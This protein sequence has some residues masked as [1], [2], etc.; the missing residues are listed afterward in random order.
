MSI[1]PPGSE[2]DGRYTV[3]QLLGEGGMNRVYLV[4]DKKG[5]RFALKVSRDPSELHGGGDDLQAHFFRE[6]AI[7]KLLSH[8]SLPRLYDHF[9]A[10]SQ[11]Y[12]I[13]EYVMGTSL[14]E[15]ARQNTLSE[16]EVLEL[17]ITLLGILEYLH[18][19]K[20]V[21]RDLKP[22]NIIV[23]PDGRLKL[24]DFDIARFYKHGKASDT[25]ALGTPGYAA[26]ETYGKA[27]SDSRSDLYSLGAT[28]HQLLTGLD[29]QHRPFRFQTSSLSGV[30]SD[31]ATA[32]EKALKLDP[33]ERFPSAAE[34][35]K[36]LERIRSSLSPSKDA[37]ARLL[38]AVSSF[39]LTMKQ[40]GTDA[41]NT[42]REAGALISKTPLINAVKNGDAGQVQRVLSLQVNL[43]LAT[44]VEERDEM[45]RSALHWAI[46][47][48]R[49]EIAEMLLAKGAQADSID[50]TGMTP[51]DY[52]VMY[53]RTE[54]LDTLVP[55]CLKLDLNR[56]SYRCLL[57]KAIL[58]GKSEMTR[59]LTEK[60]APLD[61]KDSE[62][63]T[64]LHCAALKGDK[65]LVDFL[66]SRG[67][68]VQVVDKN[69]MTA[70]HSAVHGGNLDIVRHFLQQGVPPDLKDSHGATALHY[71]AA[72][73]S[74]TMADFFITLGLAPDITDVQG[75]TPLERAASRGNA[76]IVRFLKEKGADINKCD[77]E[78]RSL[79]MRAVIAG[80]IPMSE[81]LID[82]GAAVNNSDDSG[83][84]P[85]HFAAEKGD[86]ALVKLLI[87]RGAEVNAREKRG[88]TPFYEA[89]S[90]DR[91]ELAAILLEKNADLCRGDN[92]GMTPLHV[93]ARKGRERMVKFLMDRGARADAIN[94]EGRT[95]LYYAGRKSVADL[96]RRAGSK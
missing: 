83:K 5:R 11:L 37:F 73:G 8:P 30:R 2:I 63:R 1:L 90:H 33:D 67:A 85:L 59:A 69:G 23:T 48:N 28:L 13:E 81:L 35:R 84:T 22:A 17:G 75:A 96:L 47:D 55:W 70:F 10:G 86:E 36:A 19:Q 60:G 93:A 31:L 57:H 20:I 52:V 61:V 12:L 16:A 6:V 66:L 88:R 44:T 79:L 50:N 53:N 14:E 76:E 25:V 82:G 27:Q 26:P 46:I 56:G 54:L 42:V 18:S 32:V 92:G 15:Y 41:V 43:P 68:R 77:G 51:F 91:M 24:I 64:P 78:G 58:E 39:S 7:L 45:G 38:K 95:P 34:M 80:S 9:S 49:R 3:L 21:F 72:S 4:E 87:S 40:L 71:A 89:V 74:V 65:D 62:E 29:P 94:N